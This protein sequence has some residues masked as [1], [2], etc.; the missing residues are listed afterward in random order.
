MEESRKEMKEGR[1]ELEIHCS[2]RTG[3]E[4]H[5]R[6][7][8]RRILAPIYKHWRTHCLRPFSNRLVFFSSVS[9][10]DGAKGE[11]SLNWLSYS[12]T[13]ISPQIQESF[14]LPL[15]ITLRIRVLVKQE[16]EPIPSE[17]TLPL[18]HWRPPVHCFAGQDISGKFFLLPL[19]SSRSMK[20][21]E[22]MITRFWGTELQGLSRG[23]SYIDRLAT[24]NLLFSQIPLQLPGNK[25]GNKV[26]SWLRRGVTG[27]FRTA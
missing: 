17:R 26:N 22:P 12:A 10:C 16:Q 5:L 14:F 24:S 11:S 19:A 23:R 7:Y 4:G 27:A 18:L 25:A 20:S 8:L 13:D 6:L 3:V 2:E 9:T 1:H 15:S 21:R